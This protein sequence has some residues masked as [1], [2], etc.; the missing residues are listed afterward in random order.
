M[1]GKGAP[2]F[3]LTYF[4]CYRIWQSGIAVLTAKLEIFFSH[5]IGRF[6]SAGSALPLHTAHTQD[7]VSIIISLILTR[8]LKLA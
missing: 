3:Q 4:L 5:I 8:Q 7:S 1:G 2:K 6:S